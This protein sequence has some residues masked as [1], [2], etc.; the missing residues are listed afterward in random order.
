MYWC[1]SSASARADAESCPK[2]FSTTTLPVLVRP[3]V[4]QALH[5][6]SE[7]ERGN[8]EVEDGVR[9]SAD[10]G[11]DAAVG[12]V[13]AEIT[14]D[15]REALGKPAEHV[16]VERL[17]RADDGFARPVHQLLDRPVVDRDADDRAVQQAPPL[18]PVQRPERH[19]LREIAGD[20]EDDEHVCRLLGHFALLSSSLTSVRT[21]IRLGRSWVSP[22]HVQSITAFARSSPV[23]SSAR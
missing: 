22:A 10:R 9:L 7:E 15:V 3:R 20:S 23:E 6:P 2:G 1:S 19:H 21:V 11:R 13:V 14:G 5:D 4:G 16:F 18:E 17:A 8:L 12:R